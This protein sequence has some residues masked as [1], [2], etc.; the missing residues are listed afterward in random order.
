MSDT[1][2]W[3]TLWKQLAGPIALIDLHGRHVDVNPAMCRLLGYERER[4]LELLPA[5]VTHPDDYALAK[6][7]IQNLEAGRID[8]FSAEKRLLRSDGN[9]VLVLVTS[10]LLRTSDDTP[11][12]IVSQFHDIT[13]RYGA[14][15]LWRRT[16][17]DAPI[18]MA[19]MDLEGRCTEVNARLC[20]L[21]GYPR[22]ELLGQRGSDL[23]YNGDKAQMDSLYAQFREG[24]TESASLELCLRHRDGHPFWTLTR[25]GVVQGL[26]DRP[27]YVVSQYE[28]LG[29]DAQVDEGRLAEL[30][31]MAL[32]DPLTG[33]ANRS[34]LLDRF[35]Q[36]LTKLPEQG[37]VLA[38][39][40][41]DL[42]GFKPINDRYGHDTGDRVLQAAAHEVSSAVRSSDTVARIG[43]DEFVV[44]AALAD[45]AQ[46]EELRT[47]IAQQ[48]NAAA[49]ASCRRVKLGASVG[50]TTTC[51]PST[52][53]H[54]LLASADRDMYA[55]KPARF[56]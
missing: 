48:L 23:V 5:E 7:T 24:R 25:I 4:L 16:L 27:A 2:P 8:S 30:T 28:A 43:G 46:A 37:G 18:G 26:D 36:E 51:D 17:G 52:T 21:V 32:H 34:L 19:L 12:L 56:G 10:S 31:R 22:D 15:L 20:E 54:A 50:L 6:E 45:H 49:P 39:L 35:Q 42:D 9:V 33:L 3:E 29:D 47:R 55:R 1:V 44:L 14:E 53:S 11:H 41:I 13:D 40:M 38:V